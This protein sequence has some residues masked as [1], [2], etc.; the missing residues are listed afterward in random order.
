MT[1]RRNSIANALELRFSCTNPS[2]W[3][4]KPNWWQCIS[5]GVTAVLRLAIDIIF[6]N[7]ACIIAFR[8]FFN[9]FTIQNHTTMFITITTFLFASLVSPFPVAYIEGIL[10]KGP[11]LPCVSMAGRALLA[12]YH[13]YARSIGEATSF[14]SKVCSLL[15]NFMI[16]HKKG[17]KEQVWI[18]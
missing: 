8:L 13:W 5:S 18:W 7:F 16:Y 1:E 15:I 2:I 12:G 9:M 14:P 11:Y 3:D 6:K 17:Q 10:P 4:A